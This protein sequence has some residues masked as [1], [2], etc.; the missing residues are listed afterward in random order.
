VIFGGVTVQRLADNRITLGADLG[1]TGAIYDIT[2]GAVRAFG[3][4]QIAALPGATWTPGLVLP[5]PDELCMFGGAAE[6]SS[7]LRHTEIRGAACL[8]R[9]AATWRWLA[10]P[11]TPARCGHIG[12]SFVLCGDRKT[13]HTPANWEW[14]AQD[15]YGPYEWSLWRVHVPAS[16]AGRSTAR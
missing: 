16:V 14:P 3:A 13:W 2:T 5:L 4:P 10:A 15:H 7:P 9:K 11:A 8:D 6:S 1:Q 12:S